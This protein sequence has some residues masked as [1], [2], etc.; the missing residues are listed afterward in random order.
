MKT[1]V[2]KIT[3][4]IHKSIEL[5]RNDCITIYQGPNGLVHTRGSMEYRDN[6]HHQIMVFRTMDEI[7]TT[8]KDIQRSI[9][10][11]MRSLSL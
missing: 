3:K 10:F 5:Q 7:P 2:Q 1:S 9:A 8:K 11:Q 4:Y 6:D